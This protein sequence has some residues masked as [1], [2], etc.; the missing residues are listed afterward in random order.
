[1][2]EQSR[3]PVPCVSMLQRTENAIFTAD[4]AIGRAGCHETARDR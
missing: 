2:G 3:F 4:G 1:M